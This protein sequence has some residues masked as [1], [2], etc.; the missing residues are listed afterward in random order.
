MPAHPLTASGIGAVG[1]PCSSS[2]P[3]AHL[4]LRLLTHL[5]YLL[6]YTHT[7][8]PQVL[9][10]VLLVCPLEVLRIRIAQRVGES[11]VAE[12]DGG[13]DGG[14]ATPT[15][16]APVATPQMLDSSSAANTYDGGSALAANS[17]D[18]GVIAGLGS[19]YAEGGT[20][21]LYSA[22]VPMLV[23][24]VPFTLAKFLVFD[25]TTDAISSS[26]PILQE[27]GGARRAL[28]PLPPLATARHTARPS[29]S[30]HHTHTTA[31]CIPTLNSTYTHPHTGA[32]AL[33]AGVIAGVVSGLLTTP[34]DTLVTRLANA[35]KNGEE[36]S[37]LDTARTTLA[38]DPMS[39]FSGLAP[40]C[41][42][43]GATIGGQYLLY[44]FWTRLFRVSPDDLNL[45]LDVFADRVS[46][47]GIGM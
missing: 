37:L 26:L 32:S 7:H 4:L 40:R 11:T 2:I 33:L 17:Y 20:P 27:Y 34:A 3:F 29:P 18:G 13:G 35:R 9:L 46:Y 21:L 38:T 39:L 41:L 47:G 30:S 14:V 12:S 6:T 43:F 25:A 23:R 42:L 1:A 16:S 31:M 22:L 10:S 28:S 5:P 15:A 45:V 24:E 44:D 19:L 8:P 36:A